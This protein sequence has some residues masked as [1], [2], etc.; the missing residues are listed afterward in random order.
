MQRRKRYPRDSERNREEGTVYA[1][2]KIDGSGNV[3]SVSIARS[4]GFGGLDQAI[5]EMIKQASPVPAP[6]PEA[7][8]TITVPF[9]FNLN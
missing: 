2:F 1:T 3:L 5:L 8:K 6:P 4:S 9:R 7:G